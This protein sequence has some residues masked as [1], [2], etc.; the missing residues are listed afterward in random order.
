[1]GT[2]SPLQCASFGTAPIALPA[3]LE[4]GGVDVAQVQ[5][6]VR[7]VAPRQT[8]RISQETKEFAV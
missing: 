6:P 7:K 3:F 8:W 5:V 4:I 2:S 1:M